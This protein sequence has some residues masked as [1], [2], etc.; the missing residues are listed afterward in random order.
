MQTDT[1]ASTV[2]PLHLKRSR[3]G[4][5]VGL[6]VTLAALGFLV[7]LGRWDG[8]VVPRALLGLVVVAA[9]ILRLQ[10]SRYQIEI[11]ARGICDGATREGRIGWER[12]ADID[13]EARG[14]YGALLLQLKGAAPRE[15][16]IDLAGVHVPLQAVLASALAHWQ[17]VSASSGDQQPAARD[18]APPEPRAAARAESPAVLTVGASR[19]VLITNDAGEAIFKL[20]VVSDTGASDFVSWVRNFTDEERRGQGLS[21]TEDLGWRVSTFDF[22]LSGI[23]VLGRPIRIYL[24]G[25]EGFG[26]IGQPGT[27]KDVVY[28]NAHA[29]V[30]LANDADDCGHLSAMLAAD[31]RRMQSQGQHPLCLFVAPTRAGTAGLPPD[32]HELAVSWREAPLDILKLATK[33]MLRPYF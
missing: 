3:T 6:V 13:C 12:I 11:D 23:E 14:D 2:V 25:H 32:A 30:A 18:S 8:R 5:V 19:P 17:A 16:R 21:V 31:F 20:V 10:S 7:A 24:F 27:A 29:V 28:K 33:H 1:K 26:F 15:V 4:V 22:V 9:C